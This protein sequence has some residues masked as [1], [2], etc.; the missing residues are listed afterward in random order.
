MKSVICIERASGAFSN[1]SAWAWGTW[2]RGPTVCG[3]PF[4]VLL[5][6]EGPQVC[7]KPR[8][9]CR[10]QDGGHVCKP[11]AETHVFL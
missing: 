10:V 8:L 6:Q 1:A 4:W 11:V 3:V 7:T 2:I 5:P 9:L